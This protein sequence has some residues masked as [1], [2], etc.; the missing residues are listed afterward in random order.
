MGT[1]NWKY[2][3]EMAVASCTPFAAVASLSFTDGNFT[4]A[5]TPS[6]YTTYFATST[7]GGWNVVSGSVDLI[8]GY[9]ESPPSGGN[10]VDMAG[11]TSGTINQTITG[12]TVGQLYQLSFY[13]SGNPDGPPAT[14]TLGVGLT[15]GGGTSDTFTYTIGAN[16]HGNMSYVLENVD[17]TATGPSE[18]LQ[19][20][21]QSVPGPTPWGAV[22]GGVSLTAVPEPTTMVLGALLLLPFGT[23]ALRML[24]KRP[25]A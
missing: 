15:I 17:F 19:F 7:M 25:T 11:D 14:K 3:L 13:L 2:L 23:N 6:L 4:A 24:R 16:S 8:G 5:G 9:W 1:K 10:S 18:V 20:Q 12:F 21:D 22:I